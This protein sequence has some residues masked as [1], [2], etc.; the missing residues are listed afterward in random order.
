M[1]INPKN[2]VWASFKLATGANQ[3]FNS[4]QLMSFRSESE[5]TVMLFMRNGSHYIVKGTINDILD[6]ITR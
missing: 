1:E 4:T 6:W 5:S 2:S 3:Y